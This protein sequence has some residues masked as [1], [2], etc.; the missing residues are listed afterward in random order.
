MSFVIGLG[1]FL[2]GGFMGVAVMC[3]VQV[4]RTDDRENRELKE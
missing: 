3:L 2:L 4:G 1:L